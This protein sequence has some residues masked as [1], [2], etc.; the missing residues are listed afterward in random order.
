[1]DCSL[2]LRKG[3]T[4]PIFAENTSTNSHK[5]AKFAEVFS[6]KRYMV[7]ERP[8]GGPMSYC[9]STVS[10]ALFPGLPASNL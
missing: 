1:M 6:H 8:R 10:V 3:A 4:P 2:L 7:A 5:T 9:S